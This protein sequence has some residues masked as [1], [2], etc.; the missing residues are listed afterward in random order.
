MLSPNV[1][2]STSPTYHLNTNKGR[3]IRWLQ[4][5]G[6]YRIRTPTGSHGAADSISAKLNVLIWKSYI[7]PGIA[8]T[9]A[10]SLVGQSA[11]KGCTHNFRIFF[12]FCFLRRMHAITAIISSTSILT[13]LFARLASNLG[14]GSSQR[15]SVAQRRCIKMGVQRSALRFAGAPP[16]PQKKS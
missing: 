10:T 1:R 7:A 12:T 3:G 8:A 11:T 4:E 16:P 13:L 15:Q 9:K 14:R 6:R 5:L 2:P